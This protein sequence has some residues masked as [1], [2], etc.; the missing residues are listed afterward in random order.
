[1]KLKSKEFEKLKAEWYKRLEKSGFKD[2]EQ[3]EDTLKKTT[4]ERLYKRDMIRLPFTQRY[5]ELATHLLQTFKFES[6][7]DR[8]IWSH[9]A[10]GKTVREI[11][12]RTD[13]SRFLVQKT[14]ERLSKLLTTNE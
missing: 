12:E 9:H 2:I 1:M 13:K 11:M 6:S 4:Y 10:N 5:Y 7:T 8:A 3:D 14:I